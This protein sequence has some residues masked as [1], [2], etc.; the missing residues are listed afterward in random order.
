[1]TKSDILKH[2]ASMDDDKVIMFIDANGGW[3]NLEK[4]IEK[5]GRIELTIEESPVFSND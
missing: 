2:L 4:I 3:A 5:E 1:M